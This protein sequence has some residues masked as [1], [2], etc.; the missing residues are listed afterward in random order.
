M[1][2]PFF[3][4]VEGRIPFGGLDSSGPPHIQGVRR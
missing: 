1:S 3:T 2:E 4:Q